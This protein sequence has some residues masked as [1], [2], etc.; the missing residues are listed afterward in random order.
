MLAITPLIWSSKYLILS[1]PHV[2]TCHRFRP[3]C[4][5]RSKSSRQPRQELRYRDVSNRREPCSYG[6]LIVRIGKGFAT[7]TI[8][9][10]GLL[11]SQTSS[12][13]KVWA[14][15]EGGP[16]NLGASFYEPWTLPDGFFMLGSHAQ[17]N[18]QPLTGWI[19]V[20]KET[21][22]GALKPPVDYTL[23]W[24][25]ESL[26]L[27]KE[28]NC[29]VWYP[30]P[31]DGYKAIG[32]II[33]NSPN[34]P[35]LDKVGCVRAD[36]TDQCEADT[37]I[38]GQGSIGINL[39]TSRPSTRGI[40]AQ[41]V[42][43]GTFVA[44]ISGATTPLSCL[45]NNGDISS[46]MPNLDQIKALFEAYSPYIYFHPDEQCLPSS[47][48][49]FF[50]NGALLYHKGIESNPVL[51][52]PNGTNLP[53]GGAND[54]E[55]WLDLPQDKAGKDRVTKGDLLSTE[56]YLHVKTMYGGTLTDIVVWLF[57][58]FNGSSRF[59]VKFV[60]NIELGKIGKHVGDWEHMT[61]RISN[62]NG[63]LNKV[64]FSQ[65]GGGTWV[66][67]SNLEFITG[68]KPIGYSSFR[69]HAMYS[70]PGLVLQ[71]RKGVGVQNEAAKSEMKM[72]TGVR[73]SIVAA[74]HLGNGIIEP[75]WLNYTRKWGPKIDYDIKSELKKVE[76]FLIGKLKFTFKKVVES[77]P[78]EILGEDGPTGP[79][80]K[81]NWS[82]DEV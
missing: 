38:W 27:K 13:T 65:H 17:P 31:P 55:Y 59:K 47:V 11:V 4:C 51:V 66:D 77:L 9:L 60:K 82:G 54:G 10:G 15:M 56:A 81:N 20:G 46:N 72:D 49:W 61:L 37:W 18:N 32:Y 76:K 36:L 71:G 6:V 1:L 39:F 73:Y 2:L 42:S 16:D 45:K 63:E 30:V 75:P 26:N 80:M 25:S 79:K 57:Y 74:E 34:K 24:N 44:S 29:Y 52:H 41:G 70:K 43:V 22:S 78:N 12:L 62:F 64:Y 14:T 69:G 35:P 23:V 28:G 48:N 50:S 33:T 5:R 67:A 53:Q 8:D 68:N 21:S 7:G 58:P 19:L 40:Q 3:C